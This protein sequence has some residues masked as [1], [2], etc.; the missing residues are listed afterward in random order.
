MNMLE[1]LVAQNPW[2]EGKGVEAVAGMEK[3][4]AFSLIL[5]HMGAKQI[6][7]VTGLRRVGKTVLARQL[8][9][10][11]LG[12]GVDAKRILYFSFDELLAKDPAIIEEVLETYSSLIL[13][14]ELRGVNVFFDEINHIPDWQV[15][16]KRFYDLEKDIKFLVTGSSGVRIR[17]SAESLAGRIFGFELKP[18]NFREHL[19]LRKVSIS[20]NLDVHALTLQNELVRFLT[21]GGFPELV[22]E[23]GFEKAKLYVGSIVDKIILSDIPKAG[24]VGNPEILREVFRM[25]AM[26]P[27]SL[28]EYKNLASSLKVSYQTISKYVHFL[29]TAH[30][31]RILL[32]KRGSAVAMSRK[33][34]KIYLAATSLALFS[35]ESEP[36]IL[37]LLPA[38]AENAVAL[39]LDA[40]YFWKEYYELDFLT[41]QGA[42]EVKFAERP[43]AGRNIT[44]AAKRG[45]KRLVIVTRNTEKKERRERMEVAYVPLW[46]FLLSKPAPS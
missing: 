11:L 30:I 8:I 33:A 40:R 13:R 43:D 18:L 42:V 20:G 16:L 22:Q 21:T 29:E 46:K 23:S 28:V 24:D 7:S 5:K 14:G 38:L 32:N 36:Q 25:I 31:V 39:H 10:S 1:R 2:W 12:S 9:E 4:D 19:R 27:G 41:G 17:K 44:A 35:V 6:I 37:S 45:D 15:V 26:S 3:R 34:K